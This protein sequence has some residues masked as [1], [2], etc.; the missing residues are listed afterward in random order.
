M[1]ALQG[2]AGI[3]LLFLWIF[4]II[5]VIA[6]DNAL[7]RN[8]PKPLW[9]LL[10][11]FLPAVGSIVWLIAGRPQGARLAPGSTERRAGSSAGGTGRRSAGHPG[12]MN[13][14]SPEFLRQVE[15]R[16]LNAWED[17]LRRR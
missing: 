2:A 6:T 15:E 5:D 12:P 17:N 3:A 1:I 8:L 9:L 14:D 7:I 11:L 13:E 16:R 4:C 10:V